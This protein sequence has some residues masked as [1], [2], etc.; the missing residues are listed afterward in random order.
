MGGQGVDHHARSG[1]NLGSVPDWP[2]VVTVRSAVP[3]KEA[4]VRSQIGQGGTVTAAQGAAITANEPLYVIAIS[5]IPRLFMTQAASIAKAA[6]LKRPNKEAL[7]ARDAR[8][9][10]FDRDGKQVENPPPP[11]PPAGAPRA[12]GGARGGGFGGFPEDKSGI[13]ATLFLGFAKDDPIAIDE[14][15]V[16]LSTVIGAYNVTKKFKLKEMSVSGALSF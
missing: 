6:T 2:L 1:A 10:L 5:G 8:I 3:Y 16:E 7:K 12:G 14:N 9:L 11:A 13:T 4:Q 15:E